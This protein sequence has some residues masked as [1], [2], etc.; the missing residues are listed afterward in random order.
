M[1]GTGHLLT[2]AFVKYIT[3]EGGSVLTN[4]EQI[5]GMPSGVLHRVALVRIEISKNLSPPSS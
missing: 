5:W 2:T 3:K 4:K 1:N